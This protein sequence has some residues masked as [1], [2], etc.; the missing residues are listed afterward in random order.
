MWEI[1]VTTENELI[2]KSYYQ[3]ILDKNENEHPIKI[4]G[5]MYIEEMQ[6]EQ[7]DLSFIRFA[8]GEVYFLNND[9]E[10]AIYKWQHPLD[11]KFIP[12]AQKNIADSHMEMGLFEYAEKFYKEVETDSVT[13]KSEVLLQ[14]FSLYIQQ[15]NL[16]KS[17][18]TIKNAVNLNPDY[19]DVTEIAKRYFEDIQDWDSA[20][21]LAVN[22]AIRT[23][24]LSWFEVLEGY[25][26]LGHTLNHTPNYFN[27]ALVTLL[28]IDK[29]RFERLADALWNSYQESDFYFQWLEEINRLLLNHNLEQSHT[30]KKLPT[31][32][33]EAY[34]YLISGRYLIKDISN[35]IQGHL[36]NWLE[37]S[38]VSDSLISSTAILAWNEHFPSELAAALI[39]EAE[40]HFK[41]SNPNQNGR[42][43]GIELLDS[44]KI[45][46]EKE[47]LLEGL[48][49]FM[50]P[51]LDDDYSMEMASTSSI[52]NLIKEALSYILDQKIEL[53]NVVL[54][55]I[56]W[57]EELL[58][59]L[60]DF[61]Q[62]LSNMEK[63]KATV[64]T[65]SF[66]DLKNKLIEKVQIKL[67]T[68]LRDCS[69]LVKEDDDFS[70]LHIVLNEEM[71]QRIATYMEK[72]ALPDFKQAI[73]KWIA[74]SERE[75]QESQMIC[76]AF[77]ESINQQFKEEK[78]VLSGDMKVLEDWQRDMERL[79]RG[80]LRVEDVNILLRNNPSQLLLKGA[81]KLLGPL[82][83]NKDMLLN[84]YKDYIENAEYS[85]I[86]GE[87]IRSFIQQ[88]DLFEESIEWD[89]SRFFLSPQEV[90]SNII[91]EVQADIE[92][93]NDSLNMLR[94]KPEIYRDP[95][96][97]FELKLRH[98]ELMN[99]IN[100]IS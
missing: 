94:E 27:E 67:P 11:K 97:L 36:T 68:L 1:I 38:S 72:N 40:H 99:T 45:W 88:L 76:T 5:E 35:L 44:V 52:Q 22:E 42:Q 41:N 71:N 70:K 28:Y 95:L 80:L 85:E 96:T 15:D 24:S 23:E 31:L 14:L 6:K 43:A 58:I 26:G 56:N 19:I 82:T 33:K 84:R 54:Q 51:M 63:E 30:W 86:A 13:L 79:S 18:D 39:D 47:G 34:F 73:Q 49:E 74:D 21:E 93:H 61:H 83:K 2:K 87:T 48:T 90:L 81:G 20:V 55:E 91:E 16:E 59:E 4:L 60:H 37:L 75:F 3:S 98:Y 7:P 65:S 100:A 62:E 9:Y 50:K 8:Q 66:R 25:I 64:M 53:E 89:V 69:N 57:N 77:S 29:N 92:K 17:V 46:A 32:F 12:W 78:V 10:A